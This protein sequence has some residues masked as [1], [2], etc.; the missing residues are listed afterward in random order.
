MSTKEEG[1]S[2]PGPPDLGSTSVVSESRPT[3]GALRIGI[4]FGAQYTML[5]NKEPPK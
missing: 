3:I 2:W 1:R 4:G 5:Y